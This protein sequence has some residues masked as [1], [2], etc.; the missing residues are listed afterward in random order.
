MTRLESSGRKKRNERN[1]RKVVGCRNTFIMNLLISRRRSQPQLNFPEYYKYRE[2]IFIIHHL[3]IVESSFYALQ[4]AVLCV[5]FWGRW[6]A[7]F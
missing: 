1:P 4:L 6:C 3:R 7:S 2:T 5:G